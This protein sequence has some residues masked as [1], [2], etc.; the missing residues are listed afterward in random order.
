MD[1]QRP[2]KR[3]RLWE[4]VIRVPT[5]VSHQPSTINIEKT[6][7]P[8]GVFGKRNHIP[9]RIEPLKSTS[10]SL[11]TFYKQHGGKQAYEDE[12]ERKHSERKKLREK[13]E[14]ALSK[15]PTPVKK[16]H[17]IEPLTENKMIKT[18]VFS[19][20]V[21]DSMS[22]EVVRKA[23]RNF[24]KSEIRS[25]V[26]LEMFWKIYEFESDIPQSKKDTE[27]EISEDITKMIQKKLLSV[28]QIHT[29]KK[30]LK[31][32]QT[33]LKRI[34]KYEP[35]ACVLHYLANGYKISNA[36]GNYIQDKNNRVVFIDVDYSP[37]SIKHIQDQIQMLCK[38]DSVV[39]N[40]AYA[41]KNGEPGEQISLRDVVTKI[42]CSGTDFDKKGDDKD[43]SIPIPICDGITPNLVPSICKLVESDF[44]K[45][46]ASRRI[47]FVCNNLFT[48][49][50]YIP[51]RL[52]GPR[53]TLTGPSDASIKSCATFL[54]DRTG[55]PYTSVHWT[56]KE[57]WREVMM[58]SD[59]SFV[60][61]LNQ[62]DTVSINAM[63][64]AA[65]RVKVR[66]KKIR[67]FNFNAYLNKL[68]QHPA[69]IKIELNDGHSVHYT[70]DGR[71][72]KTE[73]NIEC[74]YD[75]R[76]QSPQSIKNNGSFVEVIRDDPRIHQTTLHAVYPR[77]VDT[78]VGGYRPFNILDIHDK[79]PKNDNEESKVPSH[80]KSQSHPLQYP[81]H[82]HGL[83]HFPPNNLSNETECDIMSSIADTLCDMNVIEYDCPEEHGF[84]MENT[85]NTTIVNGADC[86]CEPPQIFMP[87]DLLSRSRCINK[88]K[89]G[90]AELY[91]RC[92]LIKSAYY[93]HLSMLRD[94]KAKIKDA[95][96]LTFVPVKK[97]ILE[98]TIVY[99]AAANM[100]STLPPEAFKR[101]PDWK[102]TMPRGTSAN[103]YAVWWSERALSG[104][105][106]LFGP[107]WQMALASFAE[108]VEDSK[109]IKQGIKSMEKCKI[110]TPT[111]LVEKLAFVLSKSKLYKAPLPNE[112]Q[113]KR[114]L[115][116]YKP[117]SC[118]ACN[119][120][121]C[122]RK[123]K[124][125]YKTMYLA[126]YVHK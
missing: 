36:S 99:F 12:C 13:E 42:W 120:C 107:P 118:M 27:K 93:E 103:D 26:S 81:A 52:L 106:D 3:Q 76:R 50:A 116:T 117:F 83:D 48:D 47:I 75:G 18:R 110:N 45:S 104:C 43:V 6:D 115:K 60:E 111:K 38:C 88:D 33:R 124:L 69:V 30:D 84:V 98:N 65:R 94:Q 82:A 102:P 96:I 89:I 5:A 16:K 80:P 114:I 7:N 85:L 63:F 67:N 73:Y 72:K 100:I 123:N 2:P 17:V 57:I 34:F 25:N 28:Y 15:K 95:E 113:Q 56:A 37:G 86:Y 92:G 4:H 68:R 14:E 74:V 59:G 121:D 122:E 8:H 109:R 87:Y 29:Q 78:L 61:R 54:E 58:P 125:V 23:T 91:D 53:C 40:V 55:K 39:V 79:R 71:L 1:D 66:F 41:M 51:F 31:W 62:A 90:G 9:K 97:G 112:K 19:D 22:L 10:I 119:K 24:F 35:R 108:L 44:I 49:P 105:V 20:D 126:S 32:M 70:D 11:E 77:A 21:V 101:N 64:G 46:C